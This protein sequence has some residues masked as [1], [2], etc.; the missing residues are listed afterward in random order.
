MKILFGDETETE[1]G[2]NLINSLAGR[3]KFCSNKCKRQWL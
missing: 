1:S 3:V 2:G